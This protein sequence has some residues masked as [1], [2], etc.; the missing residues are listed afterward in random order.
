MAN[1]GRVGDVRLVRVELAVMNA[2]NGL[3]EYCSRPRAGDCRLGLLGLKA[4]TIRHVKSR[5]ELPCVH[6]RKRAVRYRYLD[7]LALIEAR[8]VA[9]LG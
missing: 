3:A 7:I 5:S 2:S 6:L 1:M 4:G 9:P 8:S